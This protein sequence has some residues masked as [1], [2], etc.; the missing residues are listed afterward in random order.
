MQWSDISFRPPART[1]RQ[2]AALW[3]VFFGGLAAWQGLAHGN[4]AAATLL[5]ALAATIGP[6]GLLRPQTVRGIF[7]G[8]MIV[9]FPIGWVVSK[10]ILGALFYGMFTPVGLLF[11]LFGRD[12]LSL[13]RRP[14]AETYWAPKPMPADVRSYFRQS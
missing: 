4:M 3:I 11:R 8:W 1:L 7:V 2:F 13:R 9:V 10:L 12:P 14:G 6:L 5:T